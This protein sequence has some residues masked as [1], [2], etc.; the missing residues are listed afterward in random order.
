MIEREDDDY[1]VRIP[2]ALRHRPG[3]P[4]SLCCLPLSFTVTLR[5]L[6]FHT[7]M[8]RSFDELPRF[9]ASLIYTFRAEDRYCQIG[10][11]E[12]SCF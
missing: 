10:E 9:H 8:T 6:K 2:D 3:K 4:A 1:S 7:L 11:E 5:Y 12:K